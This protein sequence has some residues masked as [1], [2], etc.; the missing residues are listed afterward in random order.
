MGW[1]SRSTKL[2]HATSAAQSFV[3]YYDSNILQ[4]SPS[5]AVIDHL[6]QQVTKLQMQFPVAQRWE[7]ILFVEC[8]PSN[9]LPSSIPP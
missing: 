3:K 4:A 8:V 5:G 6:A 9:G 7:R 1:A 2:N